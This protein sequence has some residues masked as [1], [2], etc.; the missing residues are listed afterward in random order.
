MSTPT[1]GRRIGFSW[2]DSR[3]DEHDVT[4]AQFTKFVQATGYVTTA[5]RKPDWKELKKQLPPGTEKPDEC[6]LVPGSLVYSPPDHEVALN[7]L[8]QWWRWVPGAC[9]KHPQGPNSNL[10][11]KDDCPVVQVS[12]DDAVAYAKWAGKRLPTEAEWEY[13]ARGGLDQKRFAW[14]DEF[15]PNGKFMANIY[16]GKF[17]MKDS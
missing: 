16:T 2:T 9:W 8:S 15:R 4:N 11:G 5:E 13:A 7:D 1:S 10:D 14:G 3:I 6:V 17:P 12:W